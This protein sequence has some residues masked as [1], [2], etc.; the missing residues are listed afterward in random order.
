MPYEKKVNRRN[1]LNEEKIQ[2]KVP[3]S[4]DRKRFNMEIIGV[5]TGGNVQ[6]GLKLS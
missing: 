3:N 2:E 4:K 5:S 6:T 1:V